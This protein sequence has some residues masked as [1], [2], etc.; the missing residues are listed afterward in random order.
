MDLWPITI[1]ARLSLLSTYEEL[2]D[3]QWSL[4]SLCH[5]WTIRQVLAHLILA[6]RPPAR[7]YIAAV[8]RAKGDFDKANHSLAIDDAVRPTST[9][10]SDYRRVVDH[11]FSPPGWPQA[12]PLSDI[13]LHSL[14]V[15][16]PLGLETNVPADHYE[17]VLGLLFSRIGRAFTS[18]GRPTV[19]WVAVD[20]EWSRGDGPDVRGTMADLALTA[21]GRMARVQNL[22]GDGVPIV[23]D[24]LR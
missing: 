22:H 12:A 18:E 10:L 3:V 16:I 20:H 4:G 13:L 8:A 24:W 17:P 6:T 23:R 21:A 2:D 9:L 19:R 5:G 7:R 1:R 11:R 15:C 14:D